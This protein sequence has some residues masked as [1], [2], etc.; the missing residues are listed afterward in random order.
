MKPINHPYGNF[1]ILFI[2]TFKKFLKDIL[3]LILSVFFKFDKH[4]EI[5]ISSATHAPWLK[6]IEFLEFY[7]K[8]KSNSPRNSSR[9]LRS[10]RIS[11]WCRDV[12]NGQ[13][14]KV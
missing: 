8:I 14:R 10:G 4:D 12:F 11:K 6:D 7:R 3:K 1:K 13:K 9:K 2:K 5:I